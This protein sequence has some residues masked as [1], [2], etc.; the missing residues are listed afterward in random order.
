MATQKSALASRQL[1]VLYGSAQPIDGTIAIYTIRPYRLELF[2]PD[3][4]RYAAIRAC[5]LSR[6]TDVYHA[7]NLLAPSGLDA[8]RQRCGRGRESELQSVVA[9]VA[10]IDTAGSS[11]AGADYPPHTAALEALQ[12]MPLRPSIVNLSGPAGGGLHVYWALQTPVP[13]VGDRVRAKVKALSK[14]WQE[15]LRAELSPYRLD[16]TFDLVRVLRIAGCANHK[17]ENAVTRPLLVNDQRYDLCDF[18]RYAQTAPPQTTGA[19]AD[20]HAVSDPHRLARC[21][22]YLEF[23]PDAAS[24]SRGHDRTFRAACECARFGLCHA[25]A[26]RIMAWFNET[27]TPPGDKWTTAELQH[28]VKDAFH[29]VRHEGQFGTRLVG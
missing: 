28:K 4:F 14:D 7:V 12:R 3:K 15:R 2:D 5:E 16:S 24:G 21:R 10:E 13:V 8:I 25:D 19:K 6:E 9:L 22:A 27:K 18:A 17:Y 20:M 29:T 23:V 26:M 1:G 11:H